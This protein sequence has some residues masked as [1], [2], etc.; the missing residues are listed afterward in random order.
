MSITSKAATSLVR[1]TARQQVP[2]LRT[3]VAA[4]QRRTDASTSHHSFTSPFHRGGANNQDTTSTPLWKKYRNGGETSNKMFSY[5]MVGTL[6]GLSA[7]GA[8][9]TVQSMH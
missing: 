9:E 1:Q 7:L 4:S 2:A 5:F 6:G 8:K 3:A